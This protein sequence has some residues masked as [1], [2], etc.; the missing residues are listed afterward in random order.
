MDGGS[1]EGSEARFAAY[2]EAL[3]TVLGHADRQQPLHDYCLGLLMPIERKSVE[4]MAAVTA[5]AQVA[6]KHQSL[7]HFVGNAPWSDAAMLG[8]VGELVLPVIERSG[9]IE[10]WILDDTGF[11]K[12]GRHSVGVTRQYCGQLGKQD[13]CQVAVTLSLANRDASLPVAYRLYLPEDW[14]K[15]QELRRRTKIPEEIAFQTKPEIALEQIKTARAAGLP[16]GVVLMD[17]GY[18][19]DTELRAAITA[20]GISYVAGITGTTTVWPPGSAPLPPQ[21]RSGRGRPQTRLQRDPEHQPISAKALA[22]SL[23]KEAWQT[24]AWREGSAE[25]LS[26]RFARQRVRPAHRDTELSQPRAEEW[27]LIEWPENETEPTKYWLATLPEDIAFDRLVDLAKLRWRIE[28]DYQ[29]LK[30]ELG[31]GDY[32]GR[33]W[34]GFHHHA[35][36]CIAAYG[37]LIAERGALPPSGPAFSAP[38]ARSAVPESYRPRGAADPTRTAHPQLDRDGAQTAHCRTRQNPSEVPLLQWI[39]AQGTQNSGLLTQ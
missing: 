36:L 6:A 16:E 17:A 25:R 27:L 9:P 33:G 18:G 22:L 14:A 20:L 32:E 2:V 15:D 3:G 4:P 23:P 13:N 29:E 5:P 7:L 26:S 11:P 10:A 24:V 8:K 19:N 35:T 30:Q 37:F 21:T 34:R 28:R 12:K 31:L 39:D 38:L 1:G